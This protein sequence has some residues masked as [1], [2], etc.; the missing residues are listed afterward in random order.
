M[1]AKHD[2]SINWF[3]AQHIFSIAFSNDVFFSE[4]IRFYSAHAK[5]PVSQLNRLLYNAYFYH[6]LCALFNLRPQKKA[7]QKRLFFISKIEIFILKIWQHF[8]L[9]ALFTFTNRKM[10]MVRNFVSNILG[11]SR[12]WQPKKETY[13][14]KKLWIFQLMIQ[15]WDILY[16]VHR[17]RRY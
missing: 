14:V 8:L 16:H 10:Q 7:Q 6:K 15:N 1:N 3:S 12:D 4:A 2:N 13:G 17:F 5:I 9:N 11:W